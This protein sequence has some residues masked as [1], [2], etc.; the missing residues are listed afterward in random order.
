MTTLVRISHQNGPN[1]FEMVLVGF[2]R[3]PTTTDSPSSCAWYVALLARRRRLRS[4]LGVT[5]LDLLHRHGMVPVP[6]RHAQILGITRFFLFFYFF[7][8]S[9]PHPV[10]FV[11]VSV[12]SRVCCALFTL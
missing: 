9:P 5:S 12:C 11:S 1:W 6:H 4:Y 8:S 10:F 3:G 7:P 2:L